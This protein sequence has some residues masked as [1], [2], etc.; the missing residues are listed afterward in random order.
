MAY[1]AKKRPRR[2]DHIGPVEV[3]CILFVIAAVVGLLVYVIA[4][5]GGGVLMN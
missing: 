5:A 2:S 1:L 3:V 4:T